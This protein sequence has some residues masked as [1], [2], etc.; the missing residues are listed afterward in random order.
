MDKFGYNRTFI[1]LQFAK[2]FS[3]QYHIRG[4]EFCFFFIYIKINS[5]GLILLRQLKLYYK[6]LQ[7]RYM[8]YHLNRRGLI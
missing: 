5:L 3:L 1:L 2:A 4:V 6:D 8:W 7:M